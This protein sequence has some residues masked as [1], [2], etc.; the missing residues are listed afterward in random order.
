VRVDKGV[1]AGGS[2]EGAGDA[3]VGDLGKDSGCG[4]GAAA[5]AGVVRKSERPTRTRNPINWEFL[6]CQTSQKNTYELHISI[7]KCNTFQLHIYARKI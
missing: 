7:K 4:W 2:V 3:H 1:S 6:K 5:V